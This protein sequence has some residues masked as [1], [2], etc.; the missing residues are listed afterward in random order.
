M[1][2]MLANV[3][4]AWSRSRK[5]ALAYVRFGPFWAVSKVHRPTFGVV[6]HQPQLVASFFIST[7]TLD[8]MQWNFGAENGPFSRCQ[9]PQNHK[10]Q[11]LSGF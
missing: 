11:I 1:G 8:P 3:V 6:G 4:T 10:N 2:S 7:S 9:N 5:L